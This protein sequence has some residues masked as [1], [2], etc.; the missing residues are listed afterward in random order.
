MV[1]NTA[2]TPVNKTTAQ[3]TA[4]SISKIGCSTYYYPVNHTLCTNSSIQTM[5]AK[6][7]SA[8]NLLAAYCTDQYLIILS[9]GY[10]NHPHTLAY[11]PRPPGGSSTGGYASQCVTR[12]NALQFFRFKIPLYPTLLSTASGTNN[13]NYFPTGVAISSSISMPNEGYTGVTVTGLPMYPAFNN[14]GGLTWLACEVVI[15]NTLSWLFYLFCL[16]I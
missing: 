4:A 16:H 14:V 1:N 11:V 2:C 7:I 12:Q 6:G 3:Q 15:I 5:F 13:A 9:N 8:G 10:P